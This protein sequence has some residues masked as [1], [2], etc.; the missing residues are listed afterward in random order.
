MGTA[1]VIRPIASQEGI[2]IYYLSVQNCIVSIIKLVT[3]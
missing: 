3:C 1:K 2:M